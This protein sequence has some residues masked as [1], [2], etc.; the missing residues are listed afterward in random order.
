MRISDLQQINNFGQT[1][2]LTSNK[3]E[4]KKSFSE[5]L[6]NAIYKVDSLQKQADKSNDMLVAKQPENL[7]NVVIDAEKAD[8]ALQLT[9]QIR[10]KMVEAYQE[11]MRMQI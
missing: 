4:N 2:S 9:L 5:T 1:N 10:N 3:A 8:I 6:K 7:H 11:I